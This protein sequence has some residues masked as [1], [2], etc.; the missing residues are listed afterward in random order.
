M[1]NEK[2]LACSLEG[3]FPFFAIKDAIKRDILKLTSEDKT[4]KVQIVPMLLVSGNH[5]D[6]DM[7]EICEEVGE[8]CDASIVKSFT[9]DKKFNLI[10]QEEVREIFRA[11][12]EVEIKK[13]GL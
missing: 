10:E 1:I 12:I 5:Y 3:E 4:K 7:K 8:Y 13:L 2:N 11:N 6:K 9:Q